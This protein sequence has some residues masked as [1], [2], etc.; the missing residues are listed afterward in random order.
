[1]FIHTMYM[2]TALLRIAKIFAN[3]IAM[4]VFYEK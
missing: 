3:S 1:M 2:F 4:L